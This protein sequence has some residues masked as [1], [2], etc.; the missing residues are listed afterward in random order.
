[1]LILSLISWLVFGLI[2]GLIAK[3]I[4]PGNDP[5]GWIKTVCIGIIGS[6]FGGIIKVLLFGNENFSPGGLIFSI[7]GSIIFLFIWRKIIEK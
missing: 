4:M 3:A 6:Y 1:M 2:V 7:V 5:R